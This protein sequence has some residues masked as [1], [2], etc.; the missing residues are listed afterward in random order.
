MCYFNMEFEYKTRPWFRKG[1]LKRE[2]ITFAAHD[3]ISAYWLAVQE[4]KKRYRGR[5]FR[6]ELVALD[7]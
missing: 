4:G 7:S 5:Q 2:R 1:R 6:V 3:L